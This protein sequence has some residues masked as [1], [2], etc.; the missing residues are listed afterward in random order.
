M[1]TEKKLQEKITKYCKKINNVLCYKFS[2][3]SHRGVPDLIIIARGRTIYIELKSPK[4]T[5]RLS[6]LQVVTIKKMREHGAT[7]YV[8]KDYDEAIRIID[9]LCSESKLH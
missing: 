8:I 7:V 9:D 3:P 6:P 2:S 5:G 4:G 1:V